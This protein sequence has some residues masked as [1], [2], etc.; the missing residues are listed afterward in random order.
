MCQAPETV[1]P[2]DP[3]V[4]RHR[5][6]GPAAQAGGRSWA[7]CRRC[8]R[9]G[10]TVEA[11]VVA[12]HEVVLLLQGE[13]LV[14]RLVRGSGVIVGQEPFG[15]EIPVDQDPTVERDS[16]DFEAYLEEFPNGVF[17]RLAENRLAAPRSPANDAPALAGR[18]FGGGGFSGYRLSGVR[19]WRRVS[20]RARRSVSVSRFRGRW[21][22]PPAG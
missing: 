6:R 18:P 20:C 2:G 15:D 12:Q 8:R 5:D 3:R 7:R 4:S 17:R 22:E 1:E 13:D 11:E 9:C 21:I 19:R 14:H 16:A 10:P